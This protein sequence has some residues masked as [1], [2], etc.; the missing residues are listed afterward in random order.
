MFVSLLP[1]SRQFSSTWMILA[2]LFSFLSLLHVSQASITVYSQ[3]PLGQATATAAAANYTGAAQYDPKVLTPPP[4]PNP[5]PS[6][7]FTLQ[8]QSSSQAVQGLSIMQSG[9][10]L[11][12]SIEMSV[13]NQV[14]EYLP[15][16]I[17]RGIDGWFNFFK[18]GLNSW[19]PLNFIS[20][21]K[22]WILS[23]VRSSKSHFW[24]LW[25]T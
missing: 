14:R 4:I 16:F 18:V 15:Y 2:S 1:P 23:T 25:P 7:Q 5:A 11:G 24:T 21:R 8:L 6:T 13:V 19:V 10:F 22:F 12:F 9:T 17:T 20:S 3:I